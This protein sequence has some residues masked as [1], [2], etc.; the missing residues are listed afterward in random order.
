MLGKR[1]I[2]DSLGCSLEFLKS[3]VFINQVGIA[4]TP[5]CA[6]L[7]TIFSTKKPA[8]S[9]IKSGTISSQVPLL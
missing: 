9:V 6:G 1:T 5:G 3:T 2:D 8:T 7:T 4:Y